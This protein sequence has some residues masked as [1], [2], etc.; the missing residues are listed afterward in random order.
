[1]QVISRIY[2]NNFY[3]CHFLNKHKIRNFFIKSIT[4][5]D[6]RTD[7]ADV[8]FYDLSTGQLLNVYVHPFDITQDLYEF[9]SI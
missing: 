8:L 1:M 5:L 4:I 7:F 6:E 3:V 9:Y 2:E